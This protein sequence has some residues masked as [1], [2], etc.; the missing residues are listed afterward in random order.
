MKT[1]LFFPLAAV[2]LIATSC[3]V[4]RPGEIGFKQRL[5]VIRGNTIAQGV[6]MFNPFVTKVIKMN[7]QTV[8]I[9]DKLPLP[10][11]EGLSVVAEL[12]L[13]YHIQPDSAKSI[14]TRFGLNYQNKIV[15]TNFWAA[16]REI[17]ARYNAKELY[18]TERQKIEESMK[19]DLAKNISKYGF[20][21]DAVLLK[22]I[23]L[24]DQMQQAI[25]NK[26]NAEQQALQMDF[27]IEKQKKETQRMLIEAD[28]N[29]EK[30]KKEAQ[31]LIIE[32]EGIKQ[33]QQIINSSINENQL[34][35]N[36]IE[37]MKGLITSPNA[38]VIVTG[39]GN[40]PVMITT[41]KN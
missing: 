8:E 26:V 3:A 34:R 9:F 30:Q 4:V 18:A 15:V 11:K 41:D 21:V 40:Q 22:D 19:E 14:Y 7:V 24:P 37:M 31:R 1:K 5:G 20:V 25:Q 29:I 27:V 33:A 28:A 38:K 2:V 36:Q 35:Y 39:T 32:A 13:L 6:K 23:D 16:A 17:S 10:T 12:S